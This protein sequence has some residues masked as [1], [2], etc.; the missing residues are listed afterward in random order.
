MPECVCKSSIT[1]S[2]YEIGSAEKCQAIADALNA[3]YQTTE[4]VV[5]KYDP[6]KRW[7]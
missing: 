6:S 1:D 4:F 2:V 5:E 7:F 3:Q